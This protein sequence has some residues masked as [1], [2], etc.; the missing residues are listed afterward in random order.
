MDEN[1]NVEVE[2]MTESSGM[3]DVNQEITIE[4][5]SSGPSKGFVT[6]VVGAVVAVAIGAAV[7]I[8]RHKKKKPFEDLGDEEYDDSDEFVDVELEEELDAE[9]DEKD[10]SKENPDKKKKG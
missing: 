6:L 7:T 5:T 9:L 2:V 8:K 4:E 1:K 10:K 3:D